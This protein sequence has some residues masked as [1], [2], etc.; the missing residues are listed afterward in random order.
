MGLAD[1]VNCGMIEE[2]L[3]VNGFGQLKGDRLRAKDA[4]VFQYLAAAG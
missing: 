4:I 1:D 2:V 3:T